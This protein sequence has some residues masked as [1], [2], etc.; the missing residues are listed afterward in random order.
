MLTITMMTGYVI[1]AEY[2]GGPVSCEYTP[3]I[4]L[5]PE[6]RGWISAKKSFLPSLGPQQALSTTTLYLIQGMEVL[7]EIEWRN[8]SICTNTI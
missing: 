6:Q 2:Q 7:T 8:S 4:K 3:T 1:P 5:L